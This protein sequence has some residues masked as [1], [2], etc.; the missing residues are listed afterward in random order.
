MVTFVSSRLTLNREDQDRLS[1]IGNHTVPG[2]PRDSGPRNCCWAPG[3][4]HCGDSLYDICLGAQV[5]FLGGRNRARRSLGSS[6]PTAPRKEVGD[7]TFL[8]IR[9]QK[10]L[11]LDVMNTT[12][13]SCKRPIVS[14]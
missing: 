6:T 8:S 10:K 7:R 9:V 14:L 5:T 1:F 13:A 3:N 4:I 11:E 12:F 2:P